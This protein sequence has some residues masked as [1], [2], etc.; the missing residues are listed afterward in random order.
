MS[1]AR[2]G[3]GRVVHRSLRH[4][5]QR[6]HARPWSRRRRRPR[7]ERFRYVTETGLASVTTVTVGGVAASFVVVFD[8]KQTV[9]APPEDGAAIL[10]PRR[11]GFTS[12]A[13]PLIV[14]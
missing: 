2:L 1:E 8:T 11:Q 14:G 6:S 13:A 12:S 4:R 9:T 7:D 10:S 5:D 3:S